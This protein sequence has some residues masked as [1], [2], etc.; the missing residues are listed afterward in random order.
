MRSCWAFQVAPQF[1]DRSPSKGQKRRRPREDGSRDWRDGITSQGIWQPPEGARSKDGSLPSTSGGSV[2][3]LTSCCGS[4]GLQNCGGTHFYLYKPSSLWPSVTAARGATSPFHS[5]VFME[6]SS[7]L[8]NS[9][10][11][12]LSLPR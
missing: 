4:P 1:N 10:R 12:L 6:I 7:H 8:S 2:T 5:L 9:A 3:P 11:V